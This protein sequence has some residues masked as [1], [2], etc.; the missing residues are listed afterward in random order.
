[1]PRPERVLADCDS[2]AGRL[3]AGLRELR[4]SAGSPG[5]R[6]LAARAGYSST[7]L[8]DAAGGRR[9][10]ALPVVLAYVRACGGDVEE[11]RGRWHRT[12][13]ELAGAGEQSPYPGLTSFGIGDAHRFFGRARLVA[14]L[15]ENLTDHRFLAVCGASG[16]GKSSVLAAGVAA[17]AAGGTAVAGRR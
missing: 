5:Y 8:S 3:A 2:P 9:L 15:L 7:T 12:A 10:P 17:A 11:W 1:M 13:A 4:R 6:V 16:S 14:Q